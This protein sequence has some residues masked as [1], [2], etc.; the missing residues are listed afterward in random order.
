VNSGVVW[1]DKCDRGAMS[2]RRKGK[3]PQRKRGVAGTVRVTQSP[4]HVCPTRPIAAS[5]SK[6]YVGIDFQA[7]SFSVLS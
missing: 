3:L 7:L 5:S 6:F 4:W 2:A 1:P